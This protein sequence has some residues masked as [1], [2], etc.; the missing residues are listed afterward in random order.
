MF[1]GALSFSFF[2]CWTGFCGI[3][4]ENDSLKDAVDQYIFDTITTSAI[5]YGPI[6]D[7]NTKKITNMGG[8]FLNKFEFNGNISGWDTSQVTT[9]KV[10]VI[11]YI[12]ST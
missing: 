8:L 5:Y 1:F 9:M 3:E 11:D 2:L 4:F 12:I 7:W 10:C 6:S